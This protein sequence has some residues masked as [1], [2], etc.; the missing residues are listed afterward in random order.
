[1]SD[2]PV[3][4]SIVCEMLAST[5]ESSLLQINEPPPT[6]K[7]DKNGEHCLFNQTISIISWRQARISLE[8]GVIV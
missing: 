6:V 3:E 1:M 8:L 7:E 5:Q 4:S 2:Q